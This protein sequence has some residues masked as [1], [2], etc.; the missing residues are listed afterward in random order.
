MLTHQPVWLASNRMHRS[1]MTLA[2]VWQ[3]GLHV[4]VSGVKAASP[5]HYRGL[6]PCFRGLKVSPHVTRFTKFEPCA[7]P[8]QS[9]ARN[10]VVDCDPDK[11]VGPGRS[12]SA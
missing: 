9:S 10:I 2:H 6:E 3:C 11:L 4:A 7:L 1:D 8:R 5:S 12:A